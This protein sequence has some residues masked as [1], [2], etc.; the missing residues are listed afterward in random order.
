MLWKVLWRGLLDGCR[1]TWW[2]QSARSGLH[3]LAPLTREARDGAAQRVCPECGTACP[4]RAVLCPRCFYELIVNCP[5]C[6]EPV[7]VTASLCASC[8]RKPDR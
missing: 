8:H 2:E 3:C 6:G 1:W 5:H 7:S 4:A